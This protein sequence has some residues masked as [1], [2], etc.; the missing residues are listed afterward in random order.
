MA[1]HPHKGNGRELKVLIASSIA[2]SP[3]S[4]ED[5]GNGCLGWWLRFSQTRQN[6]KRRQQ[7]L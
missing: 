2:E 4:Q 3:I 7:Q 6:P 1:A 5:V